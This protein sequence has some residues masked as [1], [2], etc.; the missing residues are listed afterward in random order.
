MEN[1]LLKFLKPQGAVY[2]RRIITLREDKKSIRENAT[3]IPESKYIYMQH[4]EHEI[5]DILKQN[6]SQE[7]L[8][9]LVSRYVYEELNQPEEVQKIRLTKEQLEKFFD[10]Q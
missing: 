10:V 5:Q 8:L 4:H 3:K 7:K 2:A 9:Q 6:I 1:I